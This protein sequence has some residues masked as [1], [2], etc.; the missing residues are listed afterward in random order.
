MRRSYKYSVCNS[1][2]IDT[3]REEID[4]VIEEVSG[5]NVVNCEI[6]Q[7]VHRKRFF[8]IILIWNNL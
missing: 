5:F 4:I 1:H 3:R 8:R 6:S 7:F 2:S